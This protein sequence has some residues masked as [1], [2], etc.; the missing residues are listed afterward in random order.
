ME[1]ELPTIQQA[2]T[3]TFERINLKWKS[4][5]QEEIQNLYTS[6]LDKALERVHIPNGED[7]NISDVEHYYDSLVTAMKTCALQNIKQ[8]RYIP[9]AKPFW[10]SNLKELYNDMRLQRQYWVRVNRPRN[11]SDPSYCQYKNAKRLFRKE[12]RNE[13]LLWRKKEYEEIEKSSEVDQSTFWQLIKRKKHQGPLKTY[14]MNFEDG[15]CHTAQE[16]T[17]GWANYFSKLYARLEHPAF[18]HEFKA[19]VE[20]ELNQM[21]RNT[22]DF[23]P[24]LDGKVAEEET[25]DAVSTLKLGKTGGDD[26]LTNEHIK[27]GGTNLVYHLSSLFSLMLQCEKVPAKMK[28]GIT[29]TLLKPGKK[30]KT[31]PDSYRGITLLPVI[32]KLFE[33][34]TLHRMKTFLKTKNIIFPDPLQYAYQEHLSSLNATFGIQETINYNVERGSKVFVCLLDNRKAFDIVWHSGLFY[35]LFELGVKSKLWHLIRNAY[36]GM[37]NTVLHKGIQSKTFDILQSSRQGSIWGAFFYLVL[38]N[39]L[40]QEIREMDIGA[41]VGNIFCGIHMQADDIALVATSQRHLQQMMD[42]VYNFSCRWRFLIHPAKTKV[43]VFNESAHH[44]EQNKQSRVWNV[45][46]DRATE[47]NSHPHCGI[48][49]TT[50]SSTIQRT[51]D[52]CR[53]G[54]GVMLSLCNSV[55][56]DQHLNPIICL[57][58]YKS[59]V[60]PSALFGCELWND[61]TETEKL[62]LER[63]QHFCA[64]KI[65]HFGR[66]THS[67]ICCA[68]LGLPTIEAYMDSAKLK[69]LRRLLMLPSHCTSK[70]IFLQRLHQSKFL[71][72]IITGYSG[73]II[74]LCTKYGLT[75]SL[76]RFLTGFHF[77]DKVAWK[78][79]VNSAVREYEFTRYRVYTAND[80]DFSRFIQAHPDPSRPSPIWRVAYSHPHMLDRCFKSAKTIAYTHIWET[81]I[82]CEYCGILSMDYLAHYTLNCPYISHEHDVLWQHITNSLDVVIS[83]SLNGL[84]DDEFLVVLL[85]GPHN[86]L[87]NMNDHVAFLSI[88]INFLCKVLD[89]INVFM[90]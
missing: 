74:S 88:A 61:L 40:I 71:P 37:T 53:K 75:D 22:P 49:L 45:G 82:L 69:F 25:T 79:I 5:R 90:D 80:P 18:D 27:Y 38:I 26:S 52:A 30:V 87:N 16:V 23:S 15:V 77:P 78:H 31:D 2:S 54:R 20:C 60:L 44:R 32:Y 58:L 24:V 63:L 33:K 13:E 50:A 36:S 51:K 10:N 46:P 35:R 9:H 57:K 72:H 81:G 73:E 7:T 42:R 59:I 34:V 48:T 55:I 11:P 85:G 3:E 84:P 64:K 62:M 1:L 28:T 17:N 83:S 21:I 86:C 19:D 43:L 47:V 76:D 4:Y 66:R 29:I 89:H 14:E 8:K 65:Q 70:H 6:N 41:Y 12:M 68:M 39:A 67:S 56:Q